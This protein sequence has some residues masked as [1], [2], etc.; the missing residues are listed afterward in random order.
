M[1]KGPRWMKTLS[2]VGFSSACNCIAILAIARSWITDILHFLHSSATFCG[3]LSVSAT[4][5]VDVGDS[6]ICFKYQTFSVLS[7]YGPYLEFQPTHIGASPECLLNVTSEVQRKLCC[8]AFCNELGTL[9]RLSWIHFLNILS[10]LHFIK[11][12]YL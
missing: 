9:V 3:R 7:S 11:K 5:D 10:L 12:V 6:L 4:T 1:W 2:Y 8:C